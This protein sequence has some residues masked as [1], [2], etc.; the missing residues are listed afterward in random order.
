ML[1]RPYL[2]LLLLAT[3]AAAAC[4][5]LTSEQR[6]AACQGADW[7]SHGRND[8]AKGAAPAARADQFADCAELGYPADLAAYQSGREQGLRSYCTAESGYEAGYADR[9]YREVCPPWSELVFLQGYAR[10]A[11]ERP[12]VE[13][14]PSFGFGFGFSRFS[15]FGYHGHHHRHG[16]HGHLRGNES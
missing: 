11:A 3:L 2:A 10:G 1:S 16:H 9:R 6:I 7:A 14:Y 15:Y 8:G 12:T 13:V 4:T 5:T